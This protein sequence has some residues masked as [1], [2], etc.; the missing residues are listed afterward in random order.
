MLCVPAPRFSEPVVD[1]PTNE[2]QSTGR[3]RE[4]LLAALKGEV[5][6]DRAPIEREFGTLDNPVLVKSGFNSRVVG[7][8][9]GVEG[10]RIWII[11]SLYWQMHSDQL[12]SCTTCSIFSP[13]RYVYHC[14][15]ACITP[16]LHKKGSKVSRS[17]VVSTW[18]RQSADR[19][20]S[21]RASL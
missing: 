10:V 6:F 12:H 13:S 1:M 14:H 17:D 7:C 11:C 8:Q 3:K 21:L 18:K 5:R 4:E 2:E 9:G 19:L 20:L 16:C 15:H